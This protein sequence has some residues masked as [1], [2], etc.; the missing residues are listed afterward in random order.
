MLTANVSIFS[1]MD[2]KRTNVGKVVQ[3]SHKKCVVEEVDRKHSFII[4]K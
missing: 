2:N 3:N 1:I 4:N